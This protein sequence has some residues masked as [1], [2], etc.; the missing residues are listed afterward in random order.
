MLKIWSRDPDHATYGPSY[1]HSSRDINIS[2]FGSHIAI[3]GCLNHLAT[4]SVENP[5]LAVGIS[6]LSVVDVAT[7]SNNNYSPISKQSFLQKSTHV[8]VGSNSTSVN[9]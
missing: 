7:S 8:F 4:L 1:L 6:T 9:V 2:G 3:S 5:G